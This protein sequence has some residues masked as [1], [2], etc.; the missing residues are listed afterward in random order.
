MKKGE[1]WEGIVE[2]I[3]FP[4]KGILRIEGEKVIV[5]NALPGQRIR[6]AIHKKRGGKA[7]G[8]LLEI[9]EPSIWEKKEN[10]CPH[11]GS[12]GGCLYQ[13]F[14]YE[15]Q[16]KLKEKQVDRLIRQVCGDWG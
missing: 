7:E 13:S 2:D 14:P 15:E 12:C 10:V 8:R 3:D 1:I 11:F 9:L 5:K 16:L 6:L 4:N